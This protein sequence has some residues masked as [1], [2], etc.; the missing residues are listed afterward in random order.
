MGTRQF[1]CWFQ[2]A[3]D[4]PEKLFPQGEEDYQSKH[5]IF[6]PN[7]DMSEF[8]ENESLAILARRLQSEM[9]IIDLSDLL[10]ATDSELNEISET[11]NLSMGQKLRFR[12][13]IHNRR[14]MI[15]PHM[16]PD[17][18]LRLTNRTGRSHS[19]EI[20]REV[21]A[22]EAAS[23]P[24][25][26]VELMKKL[27]DNMELL[28]EKVDKLSDIHTVPV[29]NTKVRLEER[30]PDYTVHPKIFQKMSDDISMKDD[31]SAPQLYMTAIESIDVARKQ[32][33]C[34]RISVQLDPSIMSFD[35]RQKSLK[36]D[37]TQQ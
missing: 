30:E 31:K 27:I 2:N 25:A 9:D 14:R 24:R 7:A 23:G 3:D 10:V 28:R 32:D 13:A 6:D 18:D 5:G 21:V 1:K 22:G 36:K 33:P 15:E 8:L 17:G 16:E 11:L 20:S 34:Q 29:Q 37:P 19:R 12:K 35:K 4:A 26:D